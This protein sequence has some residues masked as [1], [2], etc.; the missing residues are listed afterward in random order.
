MAPMWNAPT[1]AYPLGSSTVCTKVYLGKFARDK[2]GI[3][4]QRR[5]SQARPVIAC[6]HSERVL[7]DW[8]LH[9][10]ARANARGFGR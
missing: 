1:N 9:S 8:R 4:E 7:R 10:A 3:V 2:A 6:S 5:N